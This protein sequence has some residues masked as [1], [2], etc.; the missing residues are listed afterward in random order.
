[1]SIEDNKA[2]MR[3][4][5]NEIWN[6]RRLELLDDLIAADYVNHA[7]PDPSLPSGAAGLKPVFES[8][9]QTFPD[10][11]FSIDDVVAEG[12]KVVTRWSM[13]ATQ[14]GEVMGMPACGK[15]VTLSGISIDRIVDGKITE[16]WRVQDDLSLAQQVGAFPGATQGG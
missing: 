3:R 15:Q 7:S 6:G 10:I 11:R 12:E 13:R 4:Y 2:V 5:F 1:V 14:R 9:L 8:V 16:H